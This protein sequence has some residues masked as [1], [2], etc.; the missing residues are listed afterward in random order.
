[1]QYDIDLYGVSQA[2]TTVSYM[3]AEFT[4]G[5]GPLALSATKFSGVILNEPIGSAEVFGI[6]AGRVL[7]GG[8]M[9]PVVGMGILGTEQAIP[10]TETLVHIG[11]GQNLITY[12]GSLPSFV[13]AYKFEE[14]T[15]RITDFSK[16]MTRTPQENAYLGMQSVFAS[17]SR[18]LNPSIPFVPD[19]PVFTTRI[20]GGQMLTP[21]MSM[22]LAGK[23]GTLWGSKFMLNKIYEGP[24]DTGTFILPGAEYTSYSRMLSQTGLKA[25]GAGTISVVDL[26]KG[27]KM[28][29]FSSSSSGITGQILKQITINDVALQT[30]AAATSISDATAKLTGISAVGYNLLGI[31]P[32]EGRA[33]SVPISTTKQATIAVPTLQT[34]VK[35]MTMPLTAQFEKVLPQTSIQASQRLCRF[36]Q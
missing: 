30:T 33:V 7:I 3:G 8:E 9:Q 27:P 15:R 34:T 1:M 23:E 25:T 21:G 32:S 22:S 13:E 20:S 16:F 14:T 11:P 35:A 5:K 10:I 6:T 31:V 26:T 24:V 17:E 36:L 18:V 19:N 12:T 28:I 29:D 4:L 2:K